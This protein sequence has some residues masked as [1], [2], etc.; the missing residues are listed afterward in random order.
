MFWNT[1][2][3]EDAQF[4][5]AKPIAEMSRDQI[6]TGLGWRWTEKRVMASILSP[7]SKVLKASIRMN[8][9][10][11]G[12][13]AYK[14]DMAN[15]NLLATNPQFRRKGVGRKILESLEKRALELGI[16]N[17][18]VQ[19]REQNRIGRL[20]YQKFGYE[21][22]DRNEN[23]YRERASGVIMYK[24]CPMKPGK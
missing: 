15:L 18:Y 1:I 9:A 24:Y 7:H 21:M 13:M 20:F 5:D 14:Q 3:L 8:F 16:E 10:G 12:I 4:S 22:I 19:V 11:F 17:L 23:Y 6:E 2:W